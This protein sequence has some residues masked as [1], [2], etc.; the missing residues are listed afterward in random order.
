MKKRASSSSL[1][2]KELLC[3]PALVHAQSGLER[4]KELKMDAPIVRESI[5]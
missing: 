4:F 2:G 5:G 1:R 3:P